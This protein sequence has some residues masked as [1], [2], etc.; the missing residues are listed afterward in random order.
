MSVTWWLDVGGQLRRDA[1]GFRDALMQLQE[2]GYLG[3]PMVI[4]RQYYD[5][6]PEAVLYCRAMDWG[7]ES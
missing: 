2:L 1:T 7:Y 4:W 6:A 3:E 5:A